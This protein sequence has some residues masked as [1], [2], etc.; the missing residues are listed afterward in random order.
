[1]V[2]LML[3]RL[4]IGDLGGLGFIINPLVRINCYKFSEHWKKENF[5][6]VYE[7]VVS[8]LNINNPAKDKEL[9]GKNIGYILFKSKSSF[10]LWCIYWE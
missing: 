9:E 8:N 1:M 5:E 4:E 7:S 10:C 6:T 3:E 2:I